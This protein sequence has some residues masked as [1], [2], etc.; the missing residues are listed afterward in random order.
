[1]GLTPFLTLGG[2]GAAAGYSISAS[3]SSMWGR[4]CTCAQWHVRI[5]VPRCTG[6]SGKAVFV[7][8]CWQHSRDSPYWE[9]Q[10]DVRVESP[11]TGWFTQTCEGSAS[12]SAS[13]APLML[14]ALTCVARRLAG[15]QRGFQAWK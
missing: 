8:I 11:V 1:M 9:L 3:V 5:T 2:G 14:M 4:C 6:Y 10:R 13:L 7:M 15:A 12:S